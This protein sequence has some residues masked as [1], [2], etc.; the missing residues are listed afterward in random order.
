MEF[1]WR[2]MTCLSDVPWTHFVEKLQVQRFI[3]LPGIQFNKEHGNMTITHFQSLKDH[4]QKKKKR[5]SDTT[6]TDFSPFA[7]IHSLTYTA[8][9]AFDPDLVKTC[10]NQ[11]KFEVN[12]IKTRWENTIFT[13]TFLTLLWPQLLAVRPGSPKLVWKWTAQWTVGHDKYTYSIVMQ[14]LKAFA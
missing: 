14:S 3:F 7:T 12:Q 10:N 13:L 1:V 5:I 6:T 2:P 4:S 9:K 8:S 11:T